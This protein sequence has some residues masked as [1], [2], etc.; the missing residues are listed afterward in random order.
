[1]AY[2]MKE[3]AELDVDKLHQDTRPNCDKCG[4]EIDENGD[5]VEDSAPNKRL[6]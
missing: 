6:N 1:M 3:L 2:T 4:R 5:P